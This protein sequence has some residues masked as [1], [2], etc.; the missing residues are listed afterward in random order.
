M[1]SASPSPSL[2]SAPFLSIRPS[3]QRLPQQPLTFG[4]GSHASR[5]NKKVAPYL[6]KK[7]SKVS[8]LLLWTLFH[9][10]LDVAIFAFNYSEYPPKKIWR[11]ITGREELSQETT[12]SNVLEKD[13]LTWSDVQRTGGNMPV[14]PA[15]TKLKTQHDAHQGELQEHVH[16]PSCSHGEGQNDINHMRLHGLIYLSGLLQLLVFLIP[17]MIRRGQRSGTVTQGDVVNAFNQQATEKEL[18]WRLNTLEPKAKGQKFQSPKDFIHDLRLTMDAFAEKVGIESLN[19]KA[20]D[21]ALKKKDPGARQVMI[22]Q[23]LEGLE[24]TNMSNKA[25]RNAFRDVVDPFLALYGLNLHE[26]A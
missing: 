10:G 5:G 15:L 17:V 2:Y 9:V 13:T 4:H 24:Q 8:W 16:S 23:W 18:P 21:G 19:W 25:V 1:Q 14:W 26:S 6:R 7:K 11:A 22:N 20:L 12:P 3:G